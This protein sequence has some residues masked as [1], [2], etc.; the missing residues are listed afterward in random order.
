M[1]GVT[2]VNAYVLGS[3]GDDDPVEGGMGDG[4]VDVWELYVMFNPDGV[5]DGLIGT[6]DDLDDPSVVLSPW[7]Y[8]DRAGDADGD[9]LANIDEYDGG[10]SP[11]NPYDV[12]TD[13]DGITDLYAWKYMLKG[14]E[15]DKDYDGDRLSNYAEYLISE[16]FQFHD[17][18]P[19]DPKTDGACV[20]YFRKVGDL[21]LG[22]LFTDHDQ[23]SDAW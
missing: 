10:H 16:V 18:D 5:Q 8:G 7:N 14:G 1:L 12:D 19:R 23:V 4:L 20:D 22:E 17:L 9:G 13:G 21:Y 6:V 2:N 11:T 3:T 15:A